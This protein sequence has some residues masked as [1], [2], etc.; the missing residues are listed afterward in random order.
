VSNS[1]SYTRQFFAHKDWIDFVDSIQAGGANGINARLHAIEQEFDAV[2]GVITQLN[3]GLGAFQPIGAAGAVVYA[4]GAVGVGGGFTSLAPPTYRLEA[5]LGANSAQSE[6]VR[7][8]NVVCCNGGVGAFAGYA[9]VA[10]KSHASDTDY[11]LRQGPNGDVQ[12][13]AASGRA[14]SIRQ[15]GT[16]IRMGVSANGNVVVGAEADL[17]GAG[18]AIFQVAGEAFKLSGSASWLIPSDARVKENV[19]DLEA[20]LAEVRKVRPVRFQYNGRAGTKAGQESVGVLGQEIEKILP[21]TIRMTPGFFDAEP[22]GEGMRIYDNS[23][24]TFVLVNAVKELAERV[25]TLER[26]LAETNARHRVAS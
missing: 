5:N 12:I 4:G 11:A 10:H 21:E 13:N 18:A 20:G 24:L 8:G 14:V 17:P 26:A 9:V 6:Q 1:I 2:S 16:S 22:D 23:A 25:E 15:N 19:R 7:L 3:A